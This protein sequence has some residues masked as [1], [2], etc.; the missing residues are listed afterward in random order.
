[1]IRKHID[2]IAI[3]VLLSGAALYSGTREFAKTSV[4]RYRTVA[5]NNVMKHALQ[6]ARSQTAQSLRSAEVQRAVETQV[7]R[8]MQPQSQCAF[9]ARLNRVI[10]MHVERA[11]EI[12]R[13][14]TQKLQCAREVSISTDST[15]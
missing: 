1:M 14:V 4:G 9:E 10:Q 2:I 6:C 7:Q 3:A 11:L 12:N 8:T 13:V 5:F 15:E